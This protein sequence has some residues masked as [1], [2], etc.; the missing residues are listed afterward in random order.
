MIASARQTWCRVREFMLAKER[1]RDVVACERA[2]LK[3]AQRRDHILL[4]IAFPQGIFALESAN[5]MNGVGSADIGHASFGKAEVAYFALLDEFADRAGHVLHGHLTIDAM[6]I[7]EVNMVGPQSLEA[8]FYRRA[9]MRGP[10]VGAAAFAILN[11]EAEFGRDHDLVALAGQ[12][13]AQ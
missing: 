1:T 9:N 12:R 5:R 6:L 10:A 2:D 11:S 3:F 8:A 13:T 7:K 4:Q